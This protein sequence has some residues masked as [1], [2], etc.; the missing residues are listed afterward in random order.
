MKALRKWFLELYEL[1]GTKQKQEVDQKGR[2][3][4]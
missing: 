4:D 3:I 1:V 2:F